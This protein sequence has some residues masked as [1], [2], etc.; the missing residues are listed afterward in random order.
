MKSFGTHLVVLMVAFLKKKCKNFLADVEKPLREKEKWEQEREQRGGNLT[1]LT[2]E[3]KERSLWR[4]YQTKDDGIFSDRY[5]PPKRALHL[6]NM[7][8]MRKKL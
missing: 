8:W 5:K 7:K 4:Q 2:Y 3:S 1:R 6:H